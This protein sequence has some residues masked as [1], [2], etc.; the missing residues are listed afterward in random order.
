MR[1]IG[2]IPVGTET[3]PQ[4]EDVD[5]CDVRN[6]SA[7]L[8][9]YAGA[10]IVDEEVDPRSGAVSDQPCPYSDAEF[11]PYPPAPSPPATLLAASIRSP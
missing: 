5:I 9:G 7:W 1:F 4:G 10:Q 11:E 6:G 8:N 3:L 2:F